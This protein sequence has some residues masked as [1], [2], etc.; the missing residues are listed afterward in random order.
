M[1]CR[2]TGTKPLYTRM[3]TNQLN[4][5]HITTFEG[6]SNEMLVKLDAEG[7]KTGDDFAG[8]A[9]DEL[10]EIVGEGVLSDE[11]AS[12]MIMRAREKWFD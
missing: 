1:A 5:I 6:L 3:I 7:I 4:I 12:E 2:R 10:Q 9:N 8:L 11:Q